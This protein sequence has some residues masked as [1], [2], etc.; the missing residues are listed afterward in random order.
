MR[1]A[2]FIYSRN[3]LR[4]LAAE[5]VFANGPEGGRLPQ[6]RIDPFLQREEA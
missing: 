1:R 6:H 3:R 4:S 5:T 2:L